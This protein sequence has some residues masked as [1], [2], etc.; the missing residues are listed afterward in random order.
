M[1]DSPTNLAAGYVAMGPYRG[2]KFLK[3]YMGV[4]M[5]VMTML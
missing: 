1:M 3:C 4:A 2:G 5:K